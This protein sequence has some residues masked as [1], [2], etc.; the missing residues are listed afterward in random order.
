MNNHLPKWA[1]FVDSQPLWRGLQICHSGYYAFL[2]IPTRS[3]DSYEYNLG[4]TCP[5]PARAHRPRA[6]YRRTCPLPANTARYSA[7][8]S[9]PPRGYKTRRPPG[10]PLPLLFPPQNLFAFGLRRHEINQVEYNSLSPPFD[11]R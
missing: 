3:M 4:D 11:H 7:P 10:K 1:S 5:S 9:A 8:G 6:H 2:R